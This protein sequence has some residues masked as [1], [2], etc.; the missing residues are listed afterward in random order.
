[1]V[2]LGHAPSQGR[3]DRRRLHEMAHEPKRI[4]PLSSSAEWRECG[5]SPASR[6]R[7]DYAS[8]GMLP[9]L[10]AGSVAL[11]SCPCML[12]SKSR[13]RAPVSTLPTMCRWLWST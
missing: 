4:H 7:V 1:M 5:H 3:L 2:P 12:S 8:V 11:A 9:G 10:F 13:F 6:V